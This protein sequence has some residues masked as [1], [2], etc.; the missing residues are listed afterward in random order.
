MFCMMQNTSVR[1][2][3]DAERMYLDGPASE[4]KFLKDLLRILDIDPSDL[5]G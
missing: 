2:D 1:L 4:K 3:R 5:I